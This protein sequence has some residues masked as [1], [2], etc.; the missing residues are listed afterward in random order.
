[1]TLF[2]LSIPFMLVAVGVAVVPLLA[3]SRSEL[4]QI[5]FDIERPRDRLR[6]VQRHGRR[7]QT[8]HSQPGPAQG[9]ARRGAVSNWHEPVLVRRQ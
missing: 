7:L 3:M 2:L 1:M 4:R 6:P 8:H 9:S 5:A